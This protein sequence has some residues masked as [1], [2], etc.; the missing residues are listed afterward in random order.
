MVVS[1]SG[2]TL[3]LPGSPLIGGLNVTP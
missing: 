3:T 1:N 2:G